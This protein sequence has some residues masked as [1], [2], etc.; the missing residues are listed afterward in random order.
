[1]KTTCLYVFFCDCCVLP[2]YLSGEAG[3]ASRRAM[4]QQLH[5]VSMYSHDEHHGTAYSWSERGEGVWFLGLAPP[6]F[7]HMTPNV[8][9]FIV[10]VRLK[11][12]YLFV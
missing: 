3:Y 6:T 4:L 8:F 2:G 5:G 12:T 10:V 11:Q 7:Y 1:M 9:L